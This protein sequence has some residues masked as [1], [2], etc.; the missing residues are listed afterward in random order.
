[1]R[2]SR[3]RPTSACAVGVEFER[4]CNDA[5]QDRK[6]ERPMLAR[7]GAACR[8]S[9]SEL[10]MWT[11]VYGVARTIFALGTLLT[12]L[13]NPTP[14]LFPPAAGIAP[15][16]FC[17]GVARVSIFCLWELEV[18]RYISIMLLLIVAS[19]WRPRWTAPLHC[20]VAF[21]LQV[22]AITLDG[23]DQVTGVITLLLLPIALTD[24]RRWHWSPSPAG[25]DARGILKKLVAASAFLVIRL[26]VAGI[27]LHSFIGKFKV[28]EWVNGTALYYWWTDPLFGAAPW[29]R[30]AT[31]QLVRSPVP[32]VLLT[33]GALLLELL[34][35][36][37]LVL[38]RRHWQWILWLGVGFHATI[39]L[40][41]GLVSFG[42]AMTAAL[43][44]YLRPTETPFGTH[45]FRLQW[46][47][48]PDS[49]R[50]MN[51]RPTEPLHE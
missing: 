8:H 45:R 7:I 22:S 41:Q 33:W 13:F 1:M 31:D 15:P 2:R 47:R 27:Y 5:K 17:T 6:A 10:D 46:R 50:D 37:A 25:T 32:L 39:A 26:Q 48:H 51:P 3:F 35:F 29:L 21:S 18:A 30:P 42:F 16:P 49:L 40:V 14:V 43:I 34:L 28:T 20:W 9:L 23:G 19:G 11:N 4:R 38:P 24:G 44:L 36:V 12:L